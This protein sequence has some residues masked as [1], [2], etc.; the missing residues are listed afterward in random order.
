[1]KPN[2]RSLVQDWKAIIDGVTGSSN[3]SRPCSINCLERIKKLIQ[4]F[5]GIFYIFFHIREHT[6]AADCFSK[7][8]LGSHLVFHY[9]LRSNADIPCFNLA[10]LEF[11]IWCSMIYFWLSMLCVDFIFGLRFDVYAQNKYIHFVGLS[12]PCW[13]SYYLNAF[14]QFWVWLYKLFILDIFLK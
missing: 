8:G 9:R 3:F 5:S 1:M 14:L 6:C 12:L 4:H 13:H 7:E 11:P 2:N 10:A